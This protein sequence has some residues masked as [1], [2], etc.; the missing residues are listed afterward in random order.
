MK[1]RV[2]FVFAAMSLIPEQMLAQAKPA[3]PNGEGDP[4]AVTCR[5]PQKLPGWPFGRFAGRVFPSLANRTR[6]GT[7]SGRTPPTVSATRPV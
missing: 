7:V 5:S 2:A 3:M 4:T 1:I 6:S